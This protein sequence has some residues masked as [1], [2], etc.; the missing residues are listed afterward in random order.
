MRRRRVSQSERLRGLGLDVLDVLH[1]VR[2]GEAGRAVTFEWWRRRFRPDQSVSSARR[3]WDRWKWE[4]RRHKVP[5]RV[6]EHDTLRPHRHGSEVPSAVHF[7]DHAGAHRRAVRL[8][9]AAAVV[10]CR[11]RGRAC[12]ERVKL[13]AA[14]AR[15]LY[16]A[17]PA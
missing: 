4:M 15:H 8:M 17:V 11:A 16:D 10:E 14:A 9:V 1:F 5:F 2:L 7:Y 3:A 13:A 6:V 12:I